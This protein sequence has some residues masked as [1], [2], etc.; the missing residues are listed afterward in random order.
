MG[1]VELSHTFTLVAGCGVNC[2]ESF[3]K[4]GDTLAQLIDTVS[5]VR[6]SGVACSL[7]ASASAV[8]KTLFGGQ[9]RDTDGAILTVNQPARGKRMGLVQWVKRFKLCNFACWLMLKEIE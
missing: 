9:K 5:Q 3:T 1:S 6:A 8:G 2:P 7:E 4:R